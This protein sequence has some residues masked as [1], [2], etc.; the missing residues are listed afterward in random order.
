MPPKQHA[1]ALRVRLD[2]AVAR[3]EQRREEALAP[4]AEGQHA[5]CHARASQ[6]HGNVLL[7]TAAAI[8]ARIMTS[9]GFALAQ[10]VAARFQTD[11]GGST[12]I[13]LA[14][15]LADP[16]NAGAATAAIAEHFG[17][18]VSGADVIHVA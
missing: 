7:D 15:K 8:V 2:A 9:R 1:D 18:A 10:P 3:A 13:E 17:V 16:G 14:V 6:R 5:T 12:G 4:N 11:A